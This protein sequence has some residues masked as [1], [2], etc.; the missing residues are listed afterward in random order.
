MV[1]P[2]CHAGKR[3]DRRE[4]FD[5][6]H[7][8]LHEHHG[9]T[10]QIDELAAAETIVRGCR[11]MRPLRQIVAGC[12]FFSAKLRREQVHCRPRQEHV[13][14]DPRKPM[15]AKAQHRLAVYAQIASRAKS[16]VWDA[17]KLASEETLNSRS[18]R[19]ESR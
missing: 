4:G 9:K 16:L 12:D 1:K 11:P 17:H 13:D 18:K 3:F 5:N 7:C 19:T 2:R 15:A 6:L 8:L 14:Q 10:R